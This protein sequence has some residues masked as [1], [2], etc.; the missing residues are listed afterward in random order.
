MDPGS[1]QFDIRPRNRGFCD[2]RHLRNRANSSQSLKMP[3]VL[4]VMGCMGLIGAAFLGGAVPSGAAHGQNSESVQRAHID[5]DVPDPAAFD[6]LLR[7][8]LLAY[9]RTIDSTGVFRGGL[10]AAAQ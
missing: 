9:F 7:R 5:A 6:S 10:P 8:D 2:A 1:R 4:K 3:H